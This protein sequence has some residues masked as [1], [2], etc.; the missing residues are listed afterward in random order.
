M[1]YF[2]ACL[3]KPP[4]GLREPGKVRVRVRIRVRVRTTSLIGGYHAAHPPG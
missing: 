1:R 3:R 2:W 4:T